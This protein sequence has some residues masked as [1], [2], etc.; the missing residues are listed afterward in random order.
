MK[1]TDINTAALEISTRRELAENPDYYGE[2]AHLCAYCGAEV[3]I[4]GT[5]EAREDLHGFLCCSDC[6]A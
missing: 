4:D 3:L 1:T 6:Q 2:A 5:I